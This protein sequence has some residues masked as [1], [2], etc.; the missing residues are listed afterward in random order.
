[1]ELRGKVMRASGRS[2]KRGVDGFDNNAMEV[3]M[4][5]FKQKKIRGKQK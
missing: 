2:W 3:C 1:M 5:L 4:Q